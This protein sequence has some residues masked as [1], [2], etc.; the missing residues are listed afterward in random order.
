MPRATQVS[1]SSATISYD[2]GCTQDV[3]SFSVN[4]VDGCSLECPLVE[5]VERIP[6]KPIPANVPRPPVPLPPNPVAVAL[7]PAPLPPV[8]L[9]PVPAPVPFVN[10]GIIA[11]VV[12]PIVVTVIDEDDDDTEAEER[13][14]GEGDEETLDTDDDE[15]EDEVG[16]LG[17][18]PPEEVPEETV[19]D[20]S[21]EELD[22]DDDETEADLPSEKK[23]VSVGAEERQ[24]AAETERGRAG[25]TLV[26]IVDEASAAPMPSS[27][28]IAGAAA[29]AGA[30]GTLKK[31]KAISST[32]GEVSYRIELP[33]GEGNI[34]LVGQERDFRSCA[35]K[36]FM[37]Q[38]M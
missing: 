16:G 8:P 33:P 27:G 7:P 19:D 9:P 23:D 32:S 13:Q 35:A 30:G 21:D 15:T 31:V 25:E 10:P 2:H 12:G 17:E 1:G 11:T 22:Q 28:E 38:E 18:E 34:F 29:L 3:S 4:D 20:D 26:D 24:F 14:E 6:E 5:L 36:Y 37:K